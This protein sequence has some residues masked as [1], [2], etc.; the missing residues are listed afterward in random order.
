MSY[1]KKD[2]GL[3]DIEDL[4]DGEH[5]GFWCISKKVTVRRADHQSQSAI[6]QKKTAI[7]ILFLFHFTLQ[8]RLFGA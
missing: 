5:M 6:K 8:R 3:N 1:T 7:K 4:L 2:R